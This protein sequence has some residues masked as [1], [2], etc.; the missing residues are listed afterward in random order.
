M[1]NL[2]SRVRHA[3]N[4]SMDFVH[5][6]AGFLQPV[7]IGSAAVFAVLGIVRLR[8][9]RRSPVIIDRRPPR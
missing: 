3:H 5:I 6:F 9:P 7:A 2:A 4:P 8:T 1:S